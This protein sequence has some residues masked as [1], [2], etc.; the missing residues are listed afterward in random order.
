MTEIT[1]LQLRP[2]DSV[3]EIWASTRRREGTLVVEVPSPSPSDVLDAQKGGLILASGDANVTAPAY[4]IDPSHV[5]AIAKQKIAGW[6]VTVLD[7]GSRMDVLNARRLHTSS[8]ST[9]E[10]K[11]RY[12]SRG[13]GFP[14]VI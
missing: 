11:Y 2:A 3:N 9:D 5:K 12:R 7:A 1:F 10:Q 13:N 4:V 14:A 6:R 8:L